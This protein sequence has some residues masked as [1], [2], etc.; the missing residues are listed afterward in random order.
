MERSLAAGTESE[1]KNLP[2][3]EVFLCDA[4]KS[5]VYFVGAGIARPRATYGRPYVAAAQ[6][7]RVRNNCPVILNPSVPAGQLPLKQQ[8]EPLIVPHT[9]IFSK[10][11][12]TGVCGI[13]REKLCKSRSVFFYAEGRKVFRKIREK[14]LELSTRPV[15]QF[16]LEPCGLGPL[17]RN[18]QPLRTPCF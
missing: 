1:N 10:N 15:E 2:L 16:F 9:K 12:S 18:P 17:F 8:G 11:F 6:F 3:R 14:R 4:Q 7:L 5:C 13:H